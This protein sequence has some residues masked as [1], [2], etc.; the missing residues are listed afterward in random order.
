MSQ[1]YLPQID[2]GDIAPF[3][4]RMERARMTFRQLNLAT[5]GSKFEDFKTEEE[6]IKHQ[7][8]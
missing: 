6:K 5:W 8:G 4:S 2:D 7:D 3:M 1:P